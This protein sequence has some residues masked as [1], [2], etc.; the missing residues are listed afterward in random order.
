[1]IE[2]VT[3]TI[4]MFIFLQFALLHLRVQKNSLVTSLHFHELFDNC[5]F[6]FLMK[7]STS[8]FGLVVQVLPSDIAN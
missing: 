4:F 1:M 2:I 6:Y 5:L 7:G 8:L 3:Q